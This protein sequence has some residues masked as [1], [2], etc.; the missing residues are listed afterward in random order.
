MPFLLLQSLPTKKRRKLKTNY[1]NKLKT[2]R[3]PH[4]KMLLNCAIKV[5]NFLL[6]SRCHNMGKPAR[7][8]IKSRPRAVY[9]SNLEDLGSNGDFNCTPFHQHTQY[10]KSPRTNARTPK[11]CANN[12]YKYN[13][14]YSIDKIKSISNYIKSTIEYTNCSSL[15]LGKLTQLTQHT[16]A[17]DNVEH[18]MKLSYASELLASSSE[19]ILKD[20]NNNSQIT[21]SNHLVR[22]SLSLYAASSLILVLCYLT[23]PLVALDTHPM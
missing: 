16:S 1:K 13:F 7:Y 17:S 20:G 19:S 11:D 4:G 2:P 14:E 6:V 10:A 3:F 15:I 18:R 21:A 9:L 12:S 23:T 8:E 5:Y 22:H